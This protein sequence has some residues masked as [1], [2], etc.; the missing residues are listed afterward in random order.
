MEN[1]TR[2]SEPYL[3]GKYY[4]I[5]D[6]AATENLT[7]E[8]AVAYSSSYFKEQDNQS[9]VRFAARISRD[10]GRAEGKAEGLI[11]G[12][13]AKLQEMVVSLRRNGFNDAQIATLINETPETIASL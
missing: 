8:E 11:E 6:A 5:F 10:E 7:N 1:L 3:S 4:E 12:A 9:A 2:K 13:K